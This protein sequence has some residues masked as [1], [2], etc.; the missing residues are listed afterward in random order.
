MLCCRWRSILEAQPHV[1]IANVP[2]TYRALLARVLPQLRPRLAV[3]QVDPTALDELLESLHP[4]LV[5]CSSLT[6]HVVRFAAAAIILYP[7]GSNEA[8]L[9]IA[10]VNRHLV[11]PQFADL[12]AAVDAVVAGGD[13]ATTIWNP[14]VADERSGSIQSHCPEL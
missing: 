5:I 4:R 2:A 1:L 7:E 8:I 9:A 10:G 6:E 3:R 12:L 13:V 14:S 11:A